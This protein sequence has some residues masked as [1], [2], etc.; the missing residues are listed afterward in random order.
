MY[1]GI[2]CVRE[3]QIDF[4]L[5][6]GEGEVIDSSKGPFGQAPFMTGMWDFFDK[7]NPRQ[8]IRSGGVIVTCPA[9]GSRESGDVRRD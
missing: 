2:R 7:R 8:P 1:E 4:I 9:T 3:N 5:A 6:I